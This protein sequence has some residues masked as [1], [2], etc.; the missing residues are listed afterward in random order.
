MVTIF[1]N[2]IAEVL[3]TESSLVVDKTQSCDSNRKDE[4]EA[5]EQLPAYAVPE[6]APNA[7]V[8]RVEDDT[9]DAQFKVVFCCYFLVEQLFFASRGRRK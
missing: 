3:Q 5:V 7:P 1:L 4:V 8:G 9:Q 6:R 2:L